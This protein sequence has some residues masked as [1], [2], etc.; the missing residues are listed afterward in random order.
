[1]HWESNPLHK[2]PDLA[3]WQYCFTASVLLNLQLDTTVPWVV[4]HWLQ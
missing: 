1:M 4:L 3:Q 2:T